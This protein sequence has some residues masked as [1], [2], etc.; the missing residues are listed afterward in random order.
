M[1]L[2]IL[3]VDDDKTLLSALKTVLDQENLVTVCNDGNKAINLCQNETQSSSG[4]T[5]Q[6]TLL[7]IIVLSSSLSAQIRILGKFNLAMNHYYFHPTDPKTP[8]Y[9]H[10]NSTPAPESV[11]F[12]GPSISFGY[13]L[14]N[15]VSIN[16]FIQPSFSI[17]PPDSSLTF[18][19]F[20]RSFSRVSQEKIDYIIPLFISVK[21]HFRW[22]NINPTLGLAIGMDLEQYTISETTTWEDSLPFTEHQTNRNYFFRFGTDLGIEWFFHQRWGLYAGVQPMFAINTQKNKLILAGATGILFSLN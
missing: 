9:R 11:Y 14:H 19:N 6:K 1:K 5:M 12:I 18:G 7:I 8:E 3:I 20:G 10:D 16:L 22:H 4:C 2:K 21:Y 17:S 15:N 13:L